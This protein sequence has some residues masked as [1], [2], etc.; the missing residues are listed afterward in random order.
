[1]NNES[2]WPTSGLRDIDDIGGLTTTNMAV[3]TIAYSAPEQL[4]GEEIDGHADQYGLAATTYHLL[5]GS[6]LFSLFN[7]AVVI[8]PPPQ[9][10]APRIGGHPS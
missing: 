10:P 5:T 3:G 9:L 2:C 8:S 6:Q 1:M 7:P 4:M